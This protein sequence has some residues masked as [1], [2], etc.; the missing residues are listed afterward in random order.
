MVPLIM[1]YVISYMEHIKIVFF[2]LVINGYGDSL[3]N[4]NYYNIDE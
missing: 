2:F 4:K 3:S 1:F